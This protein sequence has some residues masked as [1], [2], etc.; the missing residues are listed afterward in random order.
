[1]PTTIRRRHT[2]EGRPVRRHAMRYLTTAQVAAGRGTGVGRAGF[3]KELLQKGLAEGYAAAGPWEVERKGNTV[4]LLHYAFPIATAKFREDVGWT[5]TKTQG[6]PG[7]GMSASD[8]EAAWFLST[9]LMGWER[10][11]AEVE[12]PKIGKNPDPRL[13]HP[14][15]FGSRVS[16]YAFVDETRAGYLAQV[17]VQLER[18]PFGPGTPFPA[19][20]GR[21]V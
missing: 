19:R 7:Y 5:V 16:P 10:A 15:R 6:R 11:R 4:T 1:M 8:K 17:G 14:T 20:R 13:Q 9:S 3:S 21:K 12:L 2:R 18:L